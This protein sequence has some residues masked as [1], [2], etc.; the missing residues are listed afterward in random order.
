[1]RGGRWGLEAKKIQKQ[2][3]DGDKEGM[4]KVEKYRG[5]HIE[6]LQP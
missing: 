2:N 4:K 1:M 5:E 3:C 6:I